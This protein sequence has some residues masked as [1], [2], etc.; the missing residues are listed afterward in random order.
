M[1]DQAFRVCALLMILIAVRPLAAAPDPMVADFGESEGFTFSAE[2]RAR[3]DAILDATHAEVAAVFP[4]LAPTIAVSVL[5]VDRRGLDMLGGVTGRTDRPD[6]L[7]IEISR[8]YPDGVLAAVEGQLA[9][10]TF[11]ELHHTVRGWTMQGNHFGRGIQLA[12][13]NEGLAT[14]FA[15]EMTGTMKPS[16]APPADIEDWAHEV[17]ALPRDAD[18]GTWMF[19]HPDGRHSIGY[20]TGRW[21]VRRAMERS[22][23]DIVAMTDLTPVAIWAMAGFAWD[24]ELD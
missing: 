17:L 4:A 6:Q 11:H 3:I 23:L 16:D 24:R 15:E 9:T 20:R 21:V 14:V 5:P 13:I 12:V 2:E 19:S 1:H 7:L 8:T 10:T 22:G 18:Y